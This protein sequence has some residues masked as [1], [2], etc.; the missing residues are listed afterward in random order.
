MCVCVFVFTCVCVCVYV[1][2]RACVSLCV[3]A[4]A[5][6]YVSGRAGAH[7]C[8]F[9]PPPKKKSSASQFPTFITASFLTRCRQEFA[10]GKK[11]NVLHT[12]AEATTTAER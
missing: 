9:F 4:R 8:F 12:V 2:L 11:K 3:C 7:V 10:R 6:V 5:Y 1:C